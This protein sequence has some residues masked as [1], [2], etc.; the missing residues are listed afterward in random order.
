MLNFIDVSL[1]TSNP[2]QPYFVLV[3]ENGSVTAVTRHATIE[4]LV[5][6]CQQRNLPIVSSRPQI[7]AELTRHGLKV[8]PFEFRQVG[9]PI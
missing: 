8:Q 7:R 6:Y 4:S 3:F 5:Q 2:E 9:G 1:T